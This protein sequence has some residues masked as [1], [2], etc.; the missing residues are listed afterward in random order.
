MTGSTTTITAS[1]QEKQIHLDDNSSEE[2][3]KLTVKGC[4][5]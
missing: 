4:A 1:L 2:E 5:T 3:A